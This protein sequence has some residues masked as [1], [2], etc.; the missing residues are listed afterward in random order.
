M[1]ILFIPLFSLFQL[2]VCAA[3]GHTTL[4]L[5]FFIGSN[6]YNPYNIIAYSKTYSMLLTEKEKSLTNSFLGYTDRHYRK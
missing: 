1:I 4:S 3:C 2:K 6:N 5:T